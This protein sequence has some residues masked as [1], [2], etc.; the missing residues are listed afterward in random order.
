MKYLLTLL[1]L[2]PFLSF[3]QQ[4]ANT[5]ISGGVHYDALD[6]NNYG[7]G[8]RLSGGATIN[9]QLLFGIG[10]GV[11]KINGLK[12][13]I[14]PLFVQ[15][16]Y[17]DTKKNVSPIII[18]EPGY[19]V[20]KNNNGPYKTKG[21]FHFFGGG[22]ILFATRSSVKGT[23]NVGYTLYTIQSRG[24]ETR[25]KGVSIRFAVMAF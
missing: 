2:V 3:S 14:V 20:Y 21:G 25:I 1:I 23:L 11:Q 7:Y 24:V 13:P 18:A 6:Y 10:A 12:K 16:A 4:R 22:G 19:G 17:A 15:L 5:Y 8:V 9:N